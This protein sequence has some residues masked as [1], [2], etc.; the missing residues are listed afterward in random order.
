MPSRSILLLS[1]LAMVTTALFPAHEARATDS[2]IPEDVATYLAEGLVPR[3]DDLYGPGAESGS[4]I[5]F[6]ESTVVGAVVRARVFTEEYLAGAVTDTPSGVANLWIA[7]VSVAGEPIGLASIWVNPDSERPELA[8]FELDPDLLAAIAAVP[9][10][11][12]IVRDPVH[13]AWFALVDTTL[14]TLTA[15]SSGV[16]GVIDVDTYQRFLVARAGAGQQESDRPVNGGLI[17]AGTTLG[18]VV[19][20]LVVFVLLPVRRRRDAAAPPHESS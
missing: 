11:A 12:T 13:S 2:P 18:I 14:T 3:L 15:G 20:L 6:D 1:V 17:V 19:V 9:E 10:G 5:E 7:P 8:E 16:T 4:G